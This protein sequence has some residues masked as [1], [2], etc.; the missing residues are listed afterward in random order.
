LILATPCHFG[1]CDGWWRQWWP[2]CAPASS[3]DFSNLSFVWAALQIWACRVQTTCRFVFLGLELLFW[4]L[5]SKLQWQNP[6]VQTHD[7]SPRT[8]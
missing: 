6:A 8:L 4:C 7:V 1:R 3:D 2:W 5:G